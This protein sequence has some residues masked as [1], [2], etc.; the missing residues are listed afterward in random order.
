VAKKIM[1]SLLLALIEMNR[2]KDKP[3]NLGPLPRIT[4][5]MQARIRYLGA[6]GLGLILKLE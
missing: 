4:I 3:I 2:P 6:R 1:S 5:Y